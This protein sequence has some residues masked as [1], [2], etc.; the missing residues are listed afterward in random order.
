MLTNVEELI[1]EFADLDEREAC[2]LLDE[3]GREIPE[4]PKSVY[5]DENLVPG[6]QSR[7]WAACQLSDASPPTVTIQADSDA[8]VVKGLIYVVLEMFAGRTPQQILDT[9]YVQLFDRMGVGKMRWQKYLADGRRNTT[10]L[11]PELPLPPE[12]LLFLLVGPC[13]SRRRPQND[14][15]RD[16]SP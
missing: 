2:E 14:I 15:R 9:N 16:R 7:V 11:G 1:D 4:I 6:C 10:E 8:F 13:R 12:M 3:L 5:V